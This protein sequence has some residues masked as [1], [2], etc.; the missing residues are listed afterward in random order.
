MQGF[1]EG[2]AAHELRE[3]CGD[4]AG[5]ALSGHCDLI[6]GHNGRHVLR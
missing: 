1:V 2:A 6:G 5:R 4:G 3:L